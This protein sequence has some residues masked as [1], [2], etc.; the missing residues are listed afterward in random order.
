MRNLSKIGIGAATSVAALAVI[1]VANTLRQPGLPAVTGKAL[2]PPPQ[3]EAAV[4]RL[5]AAVQLA[6]VTGGDPAP[7]TALHALLADSFPL[8]HAR[9]RREVVGNASLL[10]TWPGS[11]PA[12]APILLT[13]HMDVVPVE[14]GTDGKWRYPPF[15]GTVADGYV[16]GRGTMDMKHVL[17][18]TMESVEALLARGFQPRRTVLLAFGDDEELGG[19]HGAAA[20]ADLLRQRGV[21]AQFSLDEGSVTLLDLVPGVQ[22]PIAQIGLSEKGYMSLQLSASGAG[23]HS[24]MPPAY[25]AVGRIARAV[26]RLEAQ[27]MPASLDG[28]GGA[29]LRALAPALPF[30]QRVALANSWLLAP[31]LT[32]QLAQAPTTNALIRTTTAPTMLSGGVKDNV[33]PSEAAAV[34]NFRLA[35]G[36]TLE[37]VEAHVQRV[38]DDPAVHIRR[39]LDIA[40]VATPVASA[41]GPGYRAIAAAIGQV[42][43]EA[44]VTP[45]LVVA[46][47]D[48]KHY[49]SVSQAAYRYA[50]VRMAMA[51]VAR[52]H[53]S[54]ERISTANYG[55]MIVFYRCLIEGAA[56]GR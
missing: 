1:L 46:G 48:S 23:G 42:M 55:E 6:T 33:L 32:R 43:P 24:S 36:D 49:S 54:N 50:P 22:R 16:W 12:L 39:Y 31:L 51:D 5:S 14:P 47:T 27:P 52:I 18:A 15:S 8:A 38:I 56:G 41:D 26:T 34:V 40:S 19:A 45:G 21:R 2:P 25:T 20:I 3:L 53:G 44:L 29:G 28:P 11:D 17:M 10:Y 7:F 37:Q 30:G 4:K 9:L 35:P 13:A